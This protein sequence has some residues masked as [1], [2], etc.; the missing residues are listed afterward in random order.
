[1]S[2]TKT[3]VLLLVAAFVSSATASAQPAR[4]AE[5]KS[6][7][8]AV[9]TSAD[10]AEPAES[11]AEQEQQEPAAGQPENQPDEPV[12]NADGAGEKTAEPAEQPDAESLFQ[13]GRSALFQGKYDKAIELLRQAVAADTVGRKTT[14]RL[15]LARAYRYAGRGDES[16]QLLKAI[17]EKSPDHVEAGQLLAEIY[18]TEERWKDIIDLLE[19]LLKFRHDY[20]TYHMLAEAEYNLDQYDKAR[21]HYREA[22]RLN[23]R[24]AV[25][26]YQLANI[27]LADNRFALAVK[28]YETALRLGLESPVLHYKLASAYFN[29]RNYFGKVSVVTVAAGAPGTISDN[30]YLIERVPGKKDVFRVAPAASAI[31]QIAKAMEGGLADRVDIR[32]LRANSYLNARR[33]EQ[34]YEFFTQ[35]AELISDEDKEDRALYHFYFAESAF[36]LRKYDQYMEHLRQAIQLDPE[37]Y[38]SALVDAYINVS[39]K[40]NQ[41]GQ[42]DKYTEYLALAV[43]ES[44][45]NVS[46]HLKLGYGYEEA[47]RYAEAVQQWRMVLDLEPEHPDRTK[48]LNLIKKY[49][50][51]TS[52]DADGKSADER[53]TS[54]APGVSDPCAAHALVSRAPHERLTS[55]SRAS[56]ERLTSASVASVQVPPAAS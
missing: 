1:M 56:H 11:D 20:P 18:Y 42:L 23:S 52:G 7:V 40:Y 37:S 3:L 6:E 33:Y 10:A 41:A 46:L 48:L 2:I 28:S 22:V 9:D 49:G 35:L 21:D 36:G 14:Y 29:L 51:A 8:P 39:E 43:Q 5:T 50:R 47:Q 34:A 44:P 16:E 32:M 24:S 15:H 30:W 26:H 19:P 27:Y 38:Q 31:Y 54:T 17:V 45:E 53:H 25:D 12:T 55:V 13:K 4:D